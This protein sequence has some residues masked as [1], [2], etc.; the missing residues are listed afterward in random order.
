MHDIRS[1]HRHPQIPF[2]QSID[3]DDACARCADQDRVEVDRRD[4]VATRGR[5]IEGFATTAPVQD[6]NAAGCGE[7]CALYVDPACW[8]QGVG[9]AL[10]AAARSHLAETGF[11][12]AVLWLLAGTERAERVYGR[13]GWTRDGTSRSA[14]VWG[15]TIDEL[16]YATRLCV[17]DQRGAR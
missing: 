16:R 4:L 12:T 11:N 8:G 10:L 1:S 14:P 9:R 3:D 17:P 6:R 7:L 13:D 2:D 15:I 5:H